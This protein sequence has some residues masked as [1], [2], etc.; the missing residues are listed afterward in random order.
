MG[1]LEKIPCFSILSNKKNI[2]MDSRDTR[3]N[4][5]RVKAQPWSINELYGLLIDE[6]LLMLLLLVLLL[7]LLLV[8][9]FILETYF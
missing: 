1:S 7:L 9:F 3:A 4:P 5:N 6:M 2:P 8:L